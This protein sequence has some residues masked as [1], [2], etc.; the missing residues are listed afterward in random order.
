MNSENRRMLSIYRSDILLRLIFDKLHISPLMLGILAVLSYYGGV[1]VFNLIGGTA[2]PYEWLNGL[3]DVPVFGALAEVLP[4][5]EVPAPVITDLTHTVFSTVIVFLGAV[6]FR[7]FTN[8]VPAT[9]EKLFRDQ[10]FEFDQRTY[11]LWISRVQQGYNSRRV[12]VTCFLLATPVLVTFL[13]MTHNAGLSYWWGY[14]EYGFAGYYLAIIVSVAA[15]Y[16][17]FA[18]FATVTTIRA[19]RTLKGYRLCLRPFHPDE[20][21]GLRP[22]GDL[23][24]LIYAGTIIVGIGLFTTQFLGYFGLEGSVL[25]W[26][27]IA[28]YLGIVPLI[29]ISPTASVRHVVKEAKKEELPILESKLQRCYEKIRSKIEGEHLDYEFRKQM[30]QFGK[31]REVQKVIGEISEWPFAAN[32]V[33]STVAIYLLQIVIALLPLL[34]H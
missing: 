26:L 12:K 8:T 21:S 34:G 22:L 4:F 30:E 24:V 5:K 15:Y 32:I 23:I 33:W 10:V 6:W 17:F 31:L 28:G 7:H 13:L 25:M 11:E 1:F 20:C 29:F 16:G 19:I 14:H 3:R 9:F 27:L 2:F 18:I